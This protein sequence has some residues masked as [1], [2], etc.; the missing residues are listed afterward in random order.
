MDELPGMLELQRAAADGHWPHTID[1]RTWADRF[2]ERF[3]NGGY[4]VADLIAWFANAIMAGY[5]NAKMN[6]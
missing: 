4:D 5:D 1:A 6:R 2:L 3:P